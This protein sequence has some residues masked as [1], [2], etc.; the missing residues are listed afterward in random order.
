MD[1]DFEDLA[2]LLSCTNKNG[3]SPKPTFVSCFI[4][5][6]AF[7]FLS[8]LKSLRRCLRF[9]IFW[10]RLR[11]IHY[12]PFFKGRQIILFMIYLTFWWRLLPLF[13]FWASGCEV[14]G[15]GVCVQK[16]MRWLWYA[17]WQRLRILVMA[18]GG[19]RRWTYLT[20]IKNTFNSVYFH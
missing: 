2:R 20:L 12:I 11:Q 17:L 16:Y 19:D 14:V 8:F 7:F 13:G 6:L 18:I 1:R 15:V 5:H 10:I 9:T 4:N 3:F